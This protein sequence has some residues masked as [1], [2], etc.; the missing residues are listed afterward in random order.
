MAKIILM[1]V[2]F[3]VLVVLL[4]LLTAWANG[5]ELGKTPDEMSE[6]SLAKYIVLRFFLMPAE[7][8]VKL[9]KKK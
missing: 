4:G 2:G 3:L 8:V 6:K 9:F 1:V 5:I 7:C